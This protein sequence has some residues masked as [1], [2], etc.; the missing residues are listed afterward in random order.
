MN[1]IEKIKEFFRKKEFLEIQDFDLKNFEV[2]FQN[3]DS[4]VLIDISAFIQ[5]HLTN[6]KCLKPD[7][8]LKKNESLKFREFNNLILKIDEILK[9]D[10]R[11]TYS[12]SEK[13]SWEF[14]YFIEYK[15][16]NILINNALTKTDQNFGTVI[17]SLAIIRKFDNFYFLWDLNE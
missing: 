8:S 4:E 10:F 12:E 5:T 17:Y 2:R 16:G 9:E 14:C 6:S 13:L 15:N 11:E 1:I 7:N 3:I